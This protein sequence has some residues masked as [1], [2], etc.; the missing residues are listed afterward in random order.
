MQQN[1]QEV[2]DIHPQEQHQ[3]LQVTP[4][5]CVSNDTIPYGQDVGSISVS[6]GKNDLGK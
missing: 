2:L 5:F 1:I 4:M 3:C 6:Q